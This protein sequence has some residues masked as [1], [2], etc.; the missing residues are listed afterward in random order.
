MALSNRQKMQIIDD[1]DA[2][3]IELNATS[4]PRQKMQIIDD[5][6]GLMV[7]LLGGKSAN[8]TPIKPVAPEIVEPT[9]II[10]ESPL[11]QKSDDDYINE[12]F[13]FVPEN[14]VKEVNSLNY[15]SEIDNAVQFFRGSSGNT[16][17]NFLSKL[18]RQ[19]DRNYVSIDGKSQPL[20]EYLTRAFCGYL[21]KKV[22][23]KKRNGTWDYDLI[24]SY[25]KNPNKTQVEVI[26]PTP[27]IEESPLEQKSETRTQDTNILFLQ[28]V[29]AG[30]HDN[31]NVIDLAQKV[32]DSSEI[33]VLSNDALVASAIDKFVSLDLP[34]FG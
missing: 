22:G 26:S 23:S 32:I 2:K 14:I 21:N 3:V 29:I 30:Q 24:L 8:D 17:V 19:D 18:A 7:T 28:E 4:K 11:E 15:G 5:L 13:N 25:F 33:V 6:D 12:L 10:E 20:D 34:V 1:I 31:E 27:I 9:P 16:F